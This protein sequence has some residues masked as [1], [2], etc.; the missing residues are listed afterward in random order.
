MAFVADSFIILLAQPDIE[1][2]GLLGVLLIYPL[3]MLLYYL[4]ISVNGDTGLAIILVTF[5]IRLILIPLV[6]KQQRTIE[7][8]RRWK[9]ERTK[10]VAKYNLDTPEDT[11]RRIKETT[12]LSKKYNFKPV[13]YGCLPWVYQIVIL[14]SLAQAISR[15][16]Q[17]SNQT[18]LWFT[19]GDQDPYFILNVLLML[20]IFLYMKTT[21]PE[22]I[23][24][25]YI[26][27]FIITLFS[28]LLPSAITVYLIATYLILFI[29][30]FILKT[31]LERNP[32]KMKLESN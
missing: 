16:S 18:F 1:D 21:S 4:S 23:K 25:R 27:S 12:A 9:E 10:V 11:K 22:S 2:Y 29:Q 31:Y 28:L 13:Q 7:I 3:S 6:I 24:L 14:I 8:Y 5:L 17:F 26:F 19:L 30:H 32:V 20:V 15:E